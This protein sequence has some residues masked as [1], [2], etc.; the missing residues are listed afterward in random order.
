MKAPTF[1]GVPTPEDYRAYLAQ[2]LRSVL[3]GRSESLPLA[4]CAGRILAHDVT[5]RIDVPG[6]DNSQM[7]GYALTAAA[8]TRT[9]RTFT[10][11]REIPAGRPL[12]RSRAS[13]DLAYPIM[14]GAPIPKG[15][16]AVIPVEQS[17]R[18]EYPDLPE[19]YGR[20]SETVKLAPGTPGQFVRRR[21]E[22]VTSGQVLARAGERITPA[23]LGALAAQGYTRITAACGPRVL[24]CTGGDEVLPSLTEEGHDTPA[25]LA[26]GQIHDANG[27]M[28]AALLAEDGAITRRIAIGDD[29]ALLLQHLIEEHEEFAPDLVITS[30]GISHGKYEVVR[31]A[32]AKAPA[33]ELPV[34]LSWFGH[35]SQQPGGP[36]GVSVLD[37]SGHR[38]PVLSFPGNPVSTLISYVLMLRPFLR[39][40]GPY[41]VP[42]QVASE[43]ATHKNAPRGVL[44][45]NG[46][47]TTPA[48][49]SQYL[50]GR[51][52]H[53]Q[54]QP[55]VYRVELVPD[56][57]TGSHLLHR[58]ATADVLIELAAG[59]TYTGGETVPYYRLRL[60][61]D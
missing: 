23:L 8:A 13:D 31:N 61:E 25:S 46:S 58:A 33:E 11:G 26:N 51:V 3:I 28:L 49:K 27:P 47:H 34:A 4:Q 43:A 50:R 57:L 37:F 40:G 1:D 56:V 41:G 16:D 59:V 42:L 6:F 36:Q 19:S 21:G 10:V 48:T 39:A 60:T 32:I 20:P 5:A 38:V 22:D 30:G 45:L 15:Y 9:E 7:D 53:R 24:V 52:R 35:V 18:I 17:E 14:T 2:L 54:V 55:G 29:P 44:V 12:Q